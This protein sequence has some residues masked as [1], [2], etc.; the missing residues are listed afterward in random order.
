[1]AVDIVPMLND[2]IAIAFDRNLNKFLPDRS[3]LTQKIRDGTATQKDGHRYSIGVGKSLS[4]AMQEV[5]IPDVLP[6]RRIYYNIATRTVIP[7]LQKTHQLV[8]EIDSEIQKAL[9]GKMNLG[10][11]PVMADFPYERVK[12]LVDKMTADGISYEEAAK[13]L[14]EPII[15]NTEAFHDDFIR[16]NA[17]FRESV[18]LK[19]VIIRDASSNCC[20]WCAALEGTYD[21]SSAPKEIYAR[22]EF[23][24]CDVTF[25]T[26]RKSQNVW[27][28]KIWE[29]TDEEISK[30]INYGTEE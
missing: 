9:D 25:Q 15:N 1:M 30:R 20:D 27:S 11:Q 2:R 13:W 17:E 28:K 3:K 26:E 24:R 14:G 6:D 23:C 18:G 5:M 21:Y 12:G 10:I 8:N 16:K 4:A 7:Q 19:A 29:S 22:H